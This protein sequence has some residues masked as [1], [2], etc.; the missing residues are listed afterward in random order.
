M[1]EGVGSLSDIVSHRFAPCWYIYT[2]HLFP[3]F[4]IIGFGFNGLVN[5]FYWNVL[6]A[7]IGL[8][9][10]TFDFAPVPAIYFCWIADGFIPPGLLIILAHLG[11]CL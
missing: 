9:E 10:V 8:L 11:I 2:N 7:F 1:S 5:M 4:E 3:I 6:G